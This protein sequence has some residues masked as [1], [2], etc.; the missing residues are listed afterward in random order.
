M[1]IIRTDLGN[2]R[3]SAGRIRFEPEP[4]I[5]A[6]NVQ[7]AIAQSIT[8]P[9][10]V[11]PTIVDVSMSPYAPVADDQVLLVDTSGGAVTIN[12]DA[13]ANR[14]GLSLTVKDDTGDAAVNPISVNRSGAET[15]DGLTTYTIDSA[16]GAATFWPKTG[17]YYV[18]P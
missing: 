16:Y 1:T 11:A 14:N 5:T 12:L 7:D 9:L 2:T 18:G 4:P 8:I 3:E 13:A 10:V 6:T 17:G 15:I